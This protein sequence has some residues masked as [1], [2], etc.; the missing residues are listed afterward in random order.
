[1]LLLS[2]HRENIL[3]ITKIMLPVKLRS[4]LKYLIIKKTKNI[5]LD[6]KS[7]LDNLFCHL[8][9][10]VFVLCDLRTLSMILD[11]NFKSEE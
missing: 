5:M 1:M 8:T 4:P 11:I 7:E 9:S 10:S 2:K 3:S 6:T